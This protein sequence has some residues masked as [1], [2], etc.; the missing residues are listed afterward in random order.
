MSWYRDYKNNKVKRQ[1][2][3]ANQT[4]Y[5]Y[6]N[7]IEEI[8][9]HLK[10]VEGEILL[11]AEEITGTKQENVLKSFEIIRQKCG[12]KEKSFYDILKLR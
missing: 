2:S 4:L 11:M 12:L 1:L 9:E 3:N 5:Y 6:S 10:V 8:Q 7:T